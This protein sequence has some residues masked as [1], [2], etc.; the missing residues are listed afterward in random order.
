M[1]SFVVSTQAD[2]KYEDMVK[3][4]PSSVCSRSV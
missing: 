2:H 1:V 3:N 4:Q